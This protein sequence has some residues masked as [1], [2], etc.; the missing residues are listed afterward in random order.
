MSNLLNLFHSYVVFACSAISYSFFSSSW[1][2]DSII[3]SLFSNVEPIFSNLSPIDIIVSVSTVVIA[4]SFSVY[5]SW[6]VMALVFSA[7]AEN[8]VLFSSILLFYSYASW[9]EFAGSDSVSLTA[10][11]TVL[12]PPALLEA[13]AFS[14]SGV[15]IMLALG[16]WF[17]FFEWLFSSLVLFP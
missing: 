3:W 8:V 13:K 16:S 5:I 15:K 11:L 4:I 9:W 10:S 2:L 14:C 17:S 6:L 7:P 1:C 12:T